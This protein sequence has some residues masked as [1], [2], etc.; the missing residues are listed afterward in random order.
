MA[1]TLAQLRA[2]SALRANMDDDAANSRVLTSDW[3]SLINESY[4]ELWALVESAGGDLALTAFNF[5]LASP[6]SG[7]TTTTGGM[8]VSLPADCDQVRS[9]T[10]DP[11]TDQGYALDR[12]E[13]SDRT[14]WPSDRGL[15]Y[16]PI[17]GVLHIYPAS[18]AA[19]AYRLDYVPAPT[20]L[21]ADGSTVSVVV[22]KWNEYIVLATAIKARDVEESDTRTLEMQRQRMEKR[23]KAEARRSDAGRPRKVVDVTSARWPSRL[24]PP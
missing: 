11:D 10:R 5:T 17:G 3:N 8:T 21:V 4:L 13:W 12:F 20:A 15:S 14:N 18:R 6:G 23:I 2:R 16:C 24:P 7:T 9:V 1:A 19:G 22:D